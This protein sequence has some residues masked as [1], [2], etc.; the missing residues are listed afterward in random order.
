[1]RVDGDMYESTWVTLQTMFPRLSVGGYVI[2]DDVVLPSSRKA[3]VDYRTLLGLSTDVDPLVPIDIDGAYWRRGPGPV[4]LGSSAARVPLY[5]QLLSL[6]AV[7]PPL[8]LVHS[9]RADVQLELSLHRAVWGVRTVRFVPQHDA[10]AASELTRAAGLT[11]NAGVEPRRLH[12]SC[13]A[14]SPSPAALSSSVPVH[15]AAAMLRVDALDVVYMDPVVFVNDDASRVAADG[16]V[17]ADER[18]TC[19]RVDVASRAG[20]LPVCQLLTRFDDAKAALTAWHV[21]PGAGTPHGSVEQSATLRTLR[22][23]QLL[24]FELA[25]VDAASGEA[26]LINAAFCDALSLRVATEYPTG[27]GSVDAAPPLVWDP[28]LSPALLARLR[29]GDVDAARQAATPSY[30]TAVV[31]TVAGS[32]RFAVARR[33][34]DNAYHFVRRPAVVV[35]VVRNP[36]D[37]MLH[38]LRLLFPALVWVASD[39][40][41]PVAAAWNRAVAAVTAQHAPHVLLFLSDDAR[42]DFSIVSLTDAAAAARGPHAPMTNAPKRGQTRSPMFAV[43][44]TWQAMCEATPRVCAGGA[45]SLLTLPLTPDTLALHA[46]SSRAFAASVDTL[47]VAA[48]TATP[49]TSPGAAPSPS[50]YFDVSVPAFDVDVAWTRRWMAASGEASPAT[51]LVRSAFVWHTS[52]SDTADADAAF[53]ADHELC[54]VDSAPF[55]YPLWP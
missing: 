43:R 50:M 45:A 17:S 26:L 1:M 7:Q 33:A 6:P 12:V 8:A 44:G 28:V 31:I 25:F 21:A 3:V 23:L 16:S 4:M 41:E 19:D 9:R 34:V 42:I 5:L 52:V 46:V 14:S 55:P 2:C 38:N 47:R 24:G 27:S 29:R 51:H 48:A 20:T 39:E 40:H 15:V 37:T 11:V 13:R 49:V 54:G 30:T 22:E 32:E 35:L 53:T 18:S 10:A 36:R